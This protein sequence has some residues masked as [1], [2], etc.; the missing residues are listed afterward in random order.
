[1]SVDAEPLIRH[2]LGVDPGRSR[3][4]DERVVLKRIPETAREV[5]GARYA[6]LGILNEQRDGLEGFLTAGVDGAT[7]RAIGRLPCGRGVLGTLVM[8]AQPL[9]LR[10][11]AGHAVSYGFPPG[12]PV[13]HTFLGVPVVISEQVWGN[14][15]LAEKN[16][17]EFTDVDERSAVILAEWA[18]IALDGIKNDGASR[19][20][21]PR[22][23]PRARAG[24]Q[25]A[26]RRTT[27]R[28]PQHHSRTTAR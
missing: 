23:P 24:A 17:G 6:A 15:Y 4:L 14:L 25:G 28:P 10:D 8:D 27:R 9:R 22:T 11:V 13:M 21:E 12:H 7:H 5:T 20:V 16:G 19:P 18:A 26:V 3:E 1:M 2:L